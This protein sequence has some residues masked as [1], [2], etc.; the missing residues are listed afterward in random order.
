MFRYAR[1]TPVTGVQG[2]KRPD[3]D[4]IAHRCFADQYPENTVTGLR[5]SLEYADAVEID[6]RR[7]GSGELVVFHDETLD[8]ATD[9]TG[10]I[11]DT[12]ISVLQSSTV[13][14]SPATIPTLGQFLDRVPEGTT[15]N[16]ELKET[17]I[18]AAV[19]DHCRSTDADF[20][21]SSFLPDVLVEMRTVAPRSNLAVVCAGRQ[22]GC[23]SLA[24]ELS[25]VA[26]HPML[27]L[28]TRTRLVDRA[29][30]AG[31]DVNVWT[32]KTA[33]EAETAA[34]LGVDGVITDRWDL[35][36][37]EGGSAV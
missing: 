32:I 24:S 35:F 5:R 8:R 25:A 19:W 28:A 36:E 1:N 10:S 22:N 18:A 12:P 6:V 4:V 37:R 11:S 21:F 15:V 17:G 34:D 7:C 29:Q 26:I 2:P 14:N 16:V 20:L 3:I 27:E 13:G 23:L 33:S 9:G 30:A 31:Y